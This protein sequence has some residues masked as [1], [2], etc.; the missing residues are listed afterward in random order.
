M[1]SA[2]EE[3]QSHRGTGCLDARLVAERP[4]ERA[5]GGP[6]R[7]PPQAVSHPR[8][9]ENLLFGSA[10]PRGGVR[11]GTPVGGG[12]RRGA[13]RAARTCVKEN[14][15]GGR[16]PEGDR[17]CRGRRSGG[18]GVELKPRSVATAGRRKAEKPLK[19]QPPKYVT[20]PRSP[21]TTRSRRT[22]ISEARTE[23]AGR[24]TDITRRCLRRARIFCWW[25]SGSTKIPEDLRRQIAGEPV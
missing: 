22:V 24:P 6:A 2:Q 7:P 25:R 16:V 20:S 14:L 13:S 4:V 15:V 10:G 17:A 9:G 23:R 18:K 8:T 3:T 1:R 21:R 12:R 19:P 5:C 11:L